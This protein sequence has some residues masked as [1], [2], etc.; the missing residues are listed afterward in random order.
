MTEVHVSVCAVYQP[1]HQLYKGGVLDNAACGKKLD[2][3]VLAVGFGTDGKDYYKVSRLQRHRMVQTHTNS[4]VCSVPTQSLGQE[5][6][7]SATSSSERC[8]R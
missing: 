5:L 1:D 7:V 4:A 2:H 8:T 6:V 3:G